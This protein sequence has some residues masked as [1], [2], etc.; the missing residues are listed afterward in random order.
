ME[1]NRSPYN[2]RLINPQESRRSA[3]YAV[4]FAVLL[5][6]TVPA[7]SSGNDREV[8]QD[9]RDIIEETTIVSMDDSLPPMHAF[10]SFYIIGDTLLFHDFYSTDRQF[11]GYNLNNGESL[12]WFGIYG[13]GPGEIANFGAPFIDKRNKVLYGLNCNLWSIMGFELDK[14]F[15]D[16]SY[17]AFT[18]T[19]MSDLELRVPIVKSFFTN[20]STVLCQ[21]YDMNENWTCSTS[22]IGR[23]DLETGRTVIIDDYVPEPDTR[24][25]MALSVKD[26]LICATYHTNDQINLFNLD[27]KLIKTIYGPDYH[28]PRLHKVY[29]FYEPEFCG[30]KICVVYH[31]K[32]DPTFSVGHDILMFDLE[33]N[34]LKTL[35]CEMPI[36]CLAYHEKT[37]RLYVY[38]NGDPQFGY[39]QL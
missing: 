13:S 23:L 17:R 3:F 24:F 12:G 36:T 35:R 14:A 6:L 9:E 11:F 29:Y 19:D 15:N 22:R 5:L 31:G 1:S 33:G 4:A 32:F 39:I 38:T 25:G 30:D 18:K 37:N 27:G 10:T 16:S 26:S 28:N 8:W 34:Y 7:C 20:D 21:M 2:S